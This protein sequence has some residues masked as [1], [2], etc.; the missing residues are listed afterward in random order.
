LSIVQ[1]CE[2]LGLARSSY[3]YEPVPASE[4]NLRLMRLLDEQYTRTPF[5][6]TRKMTAWLQ[7]LGYAVNR[8]RV[9]RLLRQ[10]G[11]EAIYPKPRTSLA[12]LTQQRYPYLLTGMNITR[13]NQVWSCDITY[14]RL[15]RGFIYLMAVMDWF[16]RYVLSWEISVTLDTSFC[17][18]ALDRALRVATPEIFN[19]DQGVQFTSAEFTNRLKAADIRISWDGRG[20]AFDNI[21]VERLWRS[22]KYEEVYIKDYQSVPDAV[23]HLRAYF[24][25]YNQERLHQALDYQTPAQVY[26]SR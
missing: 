2:L 13:C 16:S 5:Y 25:F 4:E 21:F 17:L 18:E 8:K 7:S 14:I 10:M 22:V 1:Q 15:Q 9:T 3:Y 11:L 19:T 23:S 24:T 6:G 20:R 12:G 26:T